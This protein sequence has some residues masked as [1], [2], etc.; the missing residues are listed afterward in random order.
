[1]HYR[2]EASDSEGWTPGPDL[3]LPCWP[4]CTVDMC[5]KETLK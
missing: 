5:L 1:M 4:G 2:K 3:R